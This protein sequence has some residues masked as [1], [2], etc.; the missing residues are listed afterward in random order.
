MDWG[1]VKECKILYVS[2]YFLI[3]SINT[4]LFLYIRD[5]RSDDGFGKIFDP[6]A[7]WWIPGWIKLA[8]STTLNL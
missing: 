3:I 5:S 6:R 8:S 4:V 7:Q 2:K 1:M